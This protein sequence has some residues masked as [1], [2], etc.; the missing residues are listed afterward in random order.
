[1][2]A[3][4]PPSRGRPSTIPAPPRMP[5]I[6]RPVATSRSVGKPA[7]AGGWSGPQTGGA[8]ISAGGCGDVR[9]LRDRARRRADGLFPY[10]ASVFTRRRWLRPRELR[11]GLYGTDAHRAC[12]RDRPTHKRNGLPGRARRTWPPRSVQEAARRRSTSRTTSTRSPGGNRTWRR[13]G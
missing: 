7:G 10:L 1:M 13:L 9:A 2:R 12:P 3:S 4:T 11:F 5:P 8:I 6:Y